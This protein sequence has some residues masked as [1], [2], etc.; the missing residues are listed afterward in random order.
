MNSFLR[1]VG[2]QL[3]LCEYRRGPLV[4]ESAPA[5]AEIVSLVVLLVVSLFS[6]LC[7]I[8]PSRAGSQEVVVPTTSY[9]S[10]QAVVNKKPETEA[11]EPISTKW[12]TMT[13]AEKR[14]RI[15]NAVLQLIS[16]HGVQGTTTARIAAEVGV[17]EPTLYRTFRNRSSMLIAAA[18]VIWQ[19]RRNEIESFEAANAMEHL[20]RLAEYHTAGIQKTRVA[21]F[22]YELAVAPPGAGLVRHLRDQQLREVQHLVT[23]IE[24]GKADGSLRS[25][26]DSYETAWRFMAVFWLEANARLHRLEDVVMSGLSSRL[27]KRILDEISTKTSPA[28]GRD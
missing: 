12:K 20:E 7:Y 21:Q 4:R 15:T 6:A 18:D 28:A 22:Q 17:S 8:Y 3:V 23:I 9:S 14:R 2:H 1:L 27:F 16:K 11:A 5:T 19:Q 26:V 10:K 13:E 24:E 25:D